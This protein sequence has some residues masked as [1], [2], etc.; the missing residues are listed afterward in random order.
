MAL[1]EMIRDLG[2]KKLSKTVQLLLQDALQANE[3]RRENG[4]TPFFHPVIIEFGTGEPCRQSAFTRDISETGIGLLH[5]TPIEPQPIVI[6]TR[7]RTDKIVG[8]N[9]DLSWCI[10]CGEG[11]YI[12]GGHFTGVVPKVR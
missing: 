7:L 9:V 2:G 4:R 12:S 11:W 8:F 3:E 1:A 10:S 5:W 6:T